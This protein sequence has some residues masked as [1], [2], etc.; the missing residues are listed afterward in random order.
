MGFII[1]TEHYWFLCTRDYILIFFQSLCAVGIL[2]HPSR[3]ILAVLRR[4][5]LLN[6]YFMLI[7][8]DVLCRFSYF[9][10]NLYISFKGL[11]TSI[12][13]EG[14]ILLCY[15]LCI[16]MWLLIGEVSPSTLCLAALFIVALSGPSIQFFK[17]KTSVS[18]FFSNERNV[19]LIT[20]NQTQKCNCP[21]CCCFNIPTSYNITFIHFAFTLFL[22]VKLQVPYCDAK[23][24]LMNCCEN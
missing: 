5:C 17:N 14:D 9:V 16:I 18:I 10:S 19:P 20:I 2:K 23:I 12:R 21:P 8:E 7:A 3:L 13:E 4:R 6:Y 11:I 1:Q 22:L 15:R 24:D